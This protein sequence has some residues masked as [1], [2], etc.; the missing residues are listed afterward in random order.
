MNLALKLREILLQQYIGAITIAFLC[1]NG[2]TDLVNAVLKPIIWY[3]NAPSAYRSVLGGITHPAAD[4]FQW[5]WMLVPLIGA[6]LQ[7]GVAYIILHWLYLKKQFV[8]LDDEPTDFADE[9]EPEPHVSQEFTVTS[10]HEPE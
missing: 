6:A 9:S 4:P 10:E 5:Q 8:L 3:M 2:I 1:V 7:L